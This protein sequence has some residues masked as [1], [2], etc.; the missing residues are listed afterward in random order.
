MSVSLSSLWLLLP[1]SLWTFPLVLTGVFP[2]S[3]N[4]SRPPWVSRTLLCI[5][6]DLNSA[7]VSMISLFLLWSRIPS[8]FLFKN[9]SRPPWVSRT[10]L[11]ILILTVPWSQWSRIPS[12]FLFKGCN[13]NWC[14][15]C[16]PQLFQ[17][18][19]KLQVFVFSFSFIFI[20]WSIETVK[21]T[22]CQVIFL[23]DQ[24]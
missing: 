23:V 22:I 1:C 4:G 2:W 8:I 24:F 17:L 10:L 20:L 15:L 21:S 6:T 3:L 12:C 18:S 7:V 11:G 19:V 16:V 9:G 5:L 14:H 13:Y